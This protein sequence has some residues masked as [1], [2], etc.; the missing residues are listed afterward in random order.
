VEPVL[1][2]ELSRNCQPAE[3]KDDF[4]DVGLSIGQRAVNFT[5]KDT[6]GAE[7]R[8][9]QLLVEMPVVMIFGSFTCPPFRQRLIATEEIQTYYDGGVKF[10]IVYIVEAHPVGSVCLYTGEEWTTSAS[11]D[12]GGNPLTQPATYQERV[13]QSTQ[14]VRE[15]GITIPVLID[16]MDNP[17]WCTY[18]PAPNIAYLIDSDGKIIGKQG[19]YDPQLMKVVIEEYL[20]S[21]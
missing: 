6:Q 8:L 17:L 19:W 18:G 10:I 1:L 13:A 16:E 21:Q 20:D 14:M 11:H 7:F 12:K 5:L 9:S 3:S 15:L 2:E 4:K